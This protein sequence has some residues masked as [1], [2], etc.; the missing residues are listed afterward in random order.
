MAMESNCLAYLWT[1]VINTSTYLTNR[2]PICSNGGL[3]PEHIYNGKAFDFNH[4]RVFGSL[5]Y[6]HVSKSQR[7]KLEAKSIKCMMVGYDDWSK[8]YRCFDPKEKKLLINKDVVFNERIIGLSTL[9]WKQTLKFDNTTIPFVLY[10]LKA[11]HGNQ[12]SINVNMK[13]MIH[14]DEPTIDEL[15]LHGNERLA[16]DQSHHSKHEV[17]QHPKEVVQRTKGLMK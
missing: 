15:S 6:V 5:A 3:S 16:N 12:G 1:K 10:N 13:S 11:N 17:V 14:D 4:L 7:S 9:P 2:N 8:A